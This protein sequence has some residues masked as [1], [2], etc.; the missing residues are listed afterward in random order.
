MTADHDRAAGSVEDGRDLD[1]DPGPGGES[2]AKPRS[3]R[4]GDA[5]DDSAAGAADGSKPDPT[6]TSNGSAAAGEE[7]GAESKSLA[8]RIVVGGA[9]SAQRVAGATGIDRAIET[10]AEEA[11]VGAIES[12]ATERAIARILNGPVVEQA[13]QEALRSQAVAEALTDTVN[14]ELVD[15]VWAQV[16]DSNETQ[17]LIERIAES[18][19]VRSAI[20]S[21]GV[22]LITDI[23]TQI[24]RV[25]RALDF[26]G[27]RIA[28]RILFRPKRSTPTNHA[29]LF[30]RALALGLDL[31]L[32]NIF[33]ITT[34]AV[35][36]LVLSAV[37][38]D[39]SSGAGQE[40]VAIGGLFWFSSASVYLYTFWALSGQTPGMGFL[41]IRIEHDGN[42]GI[43]PKLAFRRLT[44]FWLAVIP[45]CL[46]F[47]GV[48]TRT[49]RRGFHDRLGHTMVFYVNPAEPD[50]PHAAAT[51]SADEVRSS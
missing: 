2:D 43:G 45:F 39:F 42:A 50:Q 48:L 26:I 16:L 13:A 4:N 21:Q 6:A 25:T 7:K 34:M 29:G 51:A 31:L 46:G 8:E 20:A 44:G 40:L 19:E 38:V 33:L 10:V 23:G 47:I 18:P 49:N 28:R 41:D 12:E 9:R 15:R 17:L 5:P 30:T 14:S 37:G 35:L 36:G 32:V 1:D 11:I 3:D 24:A 22:G 27:E